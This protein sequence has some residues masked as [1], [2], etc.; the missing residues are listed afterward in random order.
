M[1]FIDIWLKLT[2][3]IC[4]IVS[5]LVLMMMI[6]LVIFLCLGVI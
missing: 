2:F 1:D 4:L 3:G 6:S 5:A